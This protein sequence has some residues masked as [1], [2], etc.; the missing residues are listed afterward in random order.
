M[1]ISTTTTTTND[2][3]SSKQQM[4]LAATAAAAAEA[5]NIC[6]THF[7]FEVHFNF[8]E[9][10]EIEQLINYPPRFVYPYLSLSLGA[11][12]YVPR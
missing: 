10:S 9:K 8:G 6:P 3:R 12:S 1:I 5:A 4:M 7:H 2:S 11:I